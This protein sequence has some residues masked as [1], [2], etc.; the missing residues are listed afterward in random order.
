MEGPWQALHRCPYPLS[1]FCD[2][3]FIGR[4]STDEEH[5][6]EE[7]SCFINTFIILLYFI[8]TC[9]E[10]TLQQLSIYYDDNRMSYHFHKRNA[11]S[12]TFSQQIISSRLLQVIIDWQKK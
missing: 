4:P 1:A 7:N 12:T 5:T 6:N 8:L 11:M 2:T 3:G 10:L 9:K